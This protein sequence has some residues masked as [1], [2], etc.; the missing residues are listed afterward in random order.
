[1]TVTITRSAGATVTDDELR[2]VLNGAVYYGANSNAANIPTTWPATQTAQVYT[3]D[4]SGISF[5]TRTDLT[6][7]NFGV[8]FSGRRTAGNIAATVN[9]TMSITITYSVLAPL[10]L[11]DFTVSKNADNHV[12]IRFS[13]ATE[14]NVQSIFVERSTDG[15][16]FEK[17]FTVT[18]RGARNVYTKYA[19]TDKTPVKGNNYYRISEVD[20]N[21]RWYYYV[22]KLINISTKGSSFNAYYNGGQVVTN[23]SNLPGQYEVSLIDMSGITLSRK[24]VNINS[25]SAQV[26]LDAPSRTGVYIAILKGQGHS[27]SIRVAVTK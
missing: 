1:M 11:T 5:L 27:E 22:T 16:T 20:K 6:N 14:E 9:R 17:L 4:P 13:T 26:I 19:M 21:G 12:E 25:T 18:P 24:S 10:I 15:K 23:I 8:A 2:L 3:F 7:A